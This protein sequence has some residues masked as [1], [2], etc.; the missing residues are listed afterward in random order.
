MCKQLGSP[1]PKHAPLPCN[2]HIFVSKHALP[3]I[4][5]AGLATQAAQSWEDESQCTTQHCSRLSFR[6]ECQI[7]PGWGVSNAVVL[8]ACHREH[9]WLSERD[10]Q[11]R[12]R[13]ALVIS[14]LNE[15]L[16]CLGHCGVRPL[17]PP[18]GAHLV[19]NA[20]HKDCRKAGP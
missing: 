3:S 6:T 17:F 15:A 12:T 5:R 16:E 19:L 7:P 4:F 8:G 9:A 1:P 2:L 13:A 10:V 11:M 20:F 18:N 14:C